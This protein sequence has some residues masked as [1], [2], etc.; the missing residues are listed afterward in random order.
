VKAGVSVL[1]RVATIIGSANDA[2]DDAWDVR[3]ARPTAHGFEVLLGWPAGARGK[4]YG[5]PRVIPTRPLVDYLE[6]H[7]R[8]AA[9]WQLPIGRGAIKRLRRLLGHN[10]YSDADAWWQARLDDLSTMTIEEF[11]SRHNRKHSAVERAMLAYVGKRCRDAG[12]YRVPGVREIL[13]GDL[14]RAHVAYLLHISVGAVGRL[15]WMLRQEDRADAQ[16][17]NE[18][19]SPAI[20]S[21]RVDTASARMEI[22]PGAEPAP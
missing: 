17:V 4:G 20:A 16:K 13:V 14:P 3:E 6:R 11:A 21:D 7:R 19:R 22:S 18:S 2:W 10:R 8:D 12:W 5:G 9:V 15:R 1:A